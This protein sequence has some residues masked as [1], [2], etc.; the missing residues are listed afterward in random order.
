M[1]NKEFIKAAK[2]IIKNNGMCIT[3]KC[4][5]CPASGRYNGTRSCGET[6][7]KT[8]N[9]ELTEDDPIAVEDYYIMFFT[10]WLKKNES[11]QLE[12]EF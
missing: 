10:Q 5:C 12:L 11:N 9:I 3:E 1:V 8:F 7:E 4:N 6:I 2:S